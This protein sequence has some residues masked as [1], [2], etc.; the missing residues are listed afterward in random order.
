MSTCISKEAV[1]YTHLFSTLGYMAYASGVPFSTEN[2]EAGVGLVFVVY[3]EVFAALP[4]GPI[5][6]LSLIHI[7]A[8]WKLH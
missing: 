8:P 5:V 2:V 3:P 6:Q 7:S 1:S 4:G